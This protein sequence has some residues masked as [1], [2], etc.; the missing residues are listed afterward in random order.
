MLEP[1]RRRERA[2]LIAVVLS[3][4]APTSRFERG[5]RL[6]DWMSETMADTSWTICEG[7][8]GPL[9]VVAGPAGIRD[10]WFAGRAPARA[11]GARQPMPAVEAQLAEYFAGE[12]QAFEL[13]LDLHGEPLQLAVWAELGG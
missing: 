13:D 6:T 4:A 8:V 3:I 7:P 2:I 5:G 12:R 9:T 11:P 1:R 10:V